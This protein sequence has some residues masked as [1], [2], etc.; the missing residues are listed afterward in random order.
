MNVTFSTPP[1]VLCPSSTLDASDSPAQ[2]ACPLALLR[3]RTPVGLSPYYWQYV[4]C[5]CGPGYIANYTR[6]SSSNNSSNNNSSSSSSSAGPIVGMVCVP[7]PPG[8]GAAGPA[9]PW[10]G[11]LL[12]VAGGLVAGVLGLLLLRRLVPSVVRYRTMLAKKMP[13]GE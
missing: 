9:V 5:L 12:L 2:P 7:A 1:P 13:P 3:G 10:W 6:G 4:G 8:H 11:I